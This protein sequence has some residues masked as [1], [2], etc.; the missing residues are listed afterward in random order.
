VVSAHVKDGRAFDQRPNLRLL[1]VVQ[2]V[3]I[4]RA[5]VGDHAAVLVVVAGDEDGAAAGGRLGIDAVL[6]AEADLAVAVAQRGSVLVVAHTAQKDDAVGRQ[7]VLGATG[8]VLRRAAWHHDGVM[9]AKKFLENW[10]VALLGE[11]GVVSLESVLFEEALRAARLDICA[12]S[13]ERLTPK[14]LRGT[15]NLPRSGFSRH[16]RPNCFPAADI[17][18]HDRHRLQRPP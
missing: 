8:G 13:S 18:L 6:D 7:Y 2:G 4:G 15:K 10:G 11:D 14:S 1:Q 3:E 12:I 5:E 9:V 16:T 17:L